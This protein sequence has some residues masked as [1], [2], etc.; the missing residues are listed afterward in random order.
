MYHAD[1]AVIQAVSH[2]WSEHAAAAFNGHFC[3]PSDGIIATVSFNLLLY[4]CKVKCPNTN[5][6]CAGGV[7]DHTKLV[8]HNL[9]FI[10]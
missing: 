7:T 6:Y 10:S 2:F 9:D 3:Q 8:D 1:C 4:V 5:V